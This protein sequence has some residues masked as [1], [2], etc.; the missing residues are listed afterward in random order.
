VDSE[1]ASSADKRCEAPREN[2]E[3][4]IVFALTTN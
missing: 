3:L 4:S 2:R 1:A